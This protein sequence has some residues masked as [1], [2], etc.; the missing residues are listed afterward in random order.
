MQVPAGGW[1]AGRCGNRP[2]DGIASSK[3]ADPMVLRACRIGPLLCPRRWRE[4]NADVVDS[5]PPRQ[6]G[7]QH[8]RMRP[9]DV[10]SRGDLH[11]LK[12]RT[13][14]ALP[15]A[16]REEDVARD[17]DR[18]VRENVPSEVDRIRMLDRS[19]VPPL[20]QCEQAF[21]PAIDPGD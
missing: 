20:T 8:V 18:R 7:R 2:V 3:A 5:R 19:G 17:Y 4:D 11:P 16:V 14:H 15:D 21:C 6:Q 12:G 10:T 13:R 9:L 1:N